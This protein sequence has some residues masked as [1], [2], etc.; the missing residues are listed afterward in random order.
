MFIKEAYKA[1]FTS[2]GV[3]L[4]ALFFF[5]FVKGQLT[6]NRP[7]LSAIQTTFIGAVASAAAYAIAK[8][9][10]TWFGLCRY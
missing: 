6:G 8:A 1:M 7:L 3:T 2:V 4:L 5:G 10:Q 9:V